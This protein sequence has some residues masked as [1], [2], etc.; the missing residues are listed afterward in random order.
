MVVK[1]SL[2]HWRLLSSV[3]LGVL[4]ASAIMAGT[5]VYFDSLRELALKR[6]LAEQSR[7]D[8]DLVLQGEM[9]PM[10]GPAYQRVFALAHAEIDSR[11]GWMVKD[12]ITAAKSVTFFLAKPGEEGRARSGSTRTFFAALP[13]LLDAVTL[14]PES[15][16]PREHLINAAGD[17]PELEALV[18]NETAL[19]FGVGVGDRMIAVPPWSADAP[20]VVV[21]ISGTFQKKKPASPD[22]WRLA[23]GVLHADTGTSRRML[24]FYLSER[25]FMQ[26]LSPAFPK[27]GGAFAWLVVVD[28]DK[29][30]ARNAGAALAAIEG[31]HASLGGALPSY[32]QLTSLDEVL[33]DYDRKLFFNKLPMFVVLVLIA[34]VM[35]YYVGTL[36]SL[37]VEERR[38]E[39]ALLRSRGANGGQILT[40][41]VLEGVTIAAL[42]VAAGPLLT[43]VSISLLGYT[44][45]L[46]DLTG[47][48]MLKVTISSGAYLMSALGGLLGFVALMI[49]A[50]QAS[51]IGVTR[52]RQESARPSRL[53]VLQ[54]YYV[55]V[56]LLL[57]GIYMFRQLTQQGSVVATDLFG[58]AAVNQMLLAVPGIV[59]VGS[60]MVLLRL[61]P[62]A[63]ALLSKVLAR[64][65]PAGL[66]MAAWQ[67]ARNPTH[68]ARLSLL[69]ILT[70]G[71]GV[72]ASS[73]GA[74]LKRSFE[75]RVL[76]ATGSDIRIEGVSSSSAQDRGSLVEVF[77]RVQGV[78]RASP[79][80][81]G[82]GRELSDEFGQSYVMLAVDGMT[83][84]EVAWFRDD[85]SDEPMDDL[86][87]SLR[88]AR[89]PSG[90]EL[91][92]DA[93]TLWVRV[94]AD[95]PH[96]DV[97]ITARVRDAGDRI[98]SY[99]FGPLD[100]TEWKTMKTTLDLERGRF[101]SRRPPFTL[102]ALRVE[103]PNGYTG[104]QS[105]SILVDEIW[106]ESDT[107]RMEVIET[108]ESSA[109]WS[110]V[111]NIY[112]GN[113]RLR[114]SDEGFNGDSNSVLFSWSEGAYLTPRGITYHG[115][116]RTR[117]PV[118]ASKAFARASGHSPGDEFDISVAGNR[119][120]VMLVAT[121][122]HFPTMNTANSNFLIADLASLSRVADLGSL[123]S[124]SELLP[125]GRF[126][127]LDSI[128]TETTPNEVWISIPTCA[129]GGPER[130]EVVEDVR[131]K[132]SFLAGVV[133][134]R[135][136]RLADTRIDPL[137][138]AGWEALL[139]IAFASVLLL[140]C[141]GFLVH[142]YV[143]FRN[144]QLE[145]ALLRTTGFSLRQ[146]AA[147]V[148]L[149]QALV[150]V[151][152]VALGTWMGGRL[153]ATI[154]PFL[155]HDDWGA[156]VVPPFVMETSWGSLLLTF[157]AMLAVFAVISLG[158]V[159][160][161][162]R[163]SLQRV[164]RLGEM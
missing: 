81:R 48:G 85:Y 135:A 34:M 146:L 36:S 128:V 9:R 10:S 32:G 137:V 94:K 92:A 24:P 139:L 116:A 50:V 152:G 51:R 11:S 156:L 113:D 86:L 121:V 134:D 39:M 38:G 98:T 5:V 27:M 155:G 7:S 93:R 150:V 72:F 58:E 102:S 160:L 71:L 53:P 21:R 133:H 109:G 37:A 122:D 129:C 13:G 57:A 14:L 63:M 83:F 88:V 89:S 77:E 12:L 8:L 117:L 114:T 142:A 78:Q 99:D 126:V 40:V 104:L 33:K 61:F 97:I 30:D 153:G 42:A 76:H 149:E 82:N 69:L 18:S 119:K 124:A 100:S 15:R 130:G 25:A 45:A 31:L 68:Y 60:A 145:F 143:S 65:L 132:G 115:L 101:W 125:Y 19:R 49:P 164:L 91:P 79:V 16:L 52:H 161:I 162:R 43:A 66:V 163:I 44:P 120:P 108:F 106:I 29:I 103:K 4:V 73:F 90:I 159:W 112:S 110:V 158:L 41:F 70:A 67:M 147:M 123:G 56:L 80:F 75:E 20:H 148:W 138:E 157:S 84:G 107:G 2:A 136:E 96:P 54:R 26:T 62:V 55:D 140:S 95:R 1:R 154:M 105:G 17:P 6:S 131:T 118:L 64:W 111:R 144:R 47:G 87:R 23:E 141:L 151:S 74:T 59:L 22:F 46:S 35:L 127:P 3:V 28:T